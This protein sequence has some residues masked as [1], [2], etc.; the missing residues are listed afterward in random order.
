[1]D[2]FREGAHSTGSTSAVNRYFVSASSAYYPNGYRVFFLEG[3]ERP[4]KK[5]FLMGIF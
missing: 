2:V 5:V 4:G 3:R 1:M